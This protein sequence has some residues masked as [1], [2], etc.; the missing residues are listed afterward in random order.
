[1]LEG[2]RGLPHTTMPMLKGNINALEKA[3][4]KVPA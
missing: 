4:E 2:G 1:M 3:W